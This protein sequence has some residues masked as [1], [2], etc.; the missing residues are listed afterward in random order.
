MF[1]CR[2]DG[3]QQQP[4]VAVPQAGKLKLRCAAGKCRLAANGF[5]RV[6]GY[7]RPPLPAV[8][9]KGAPVPPHVFFEACW[10][11]PHLRDVAGHAQRASQGDGAVPPSGLC[12]LAK[13]W[14]MS[15]TL[16]LALT[17]SI[18]EGEV[19]HG[20]EAEA[21]TAA[22]L[23]VRYRW[24]LRSQLLDMVRNLAAVQLIGA[25]AFDV[26]HFFTKS[27]EALERLVQDL[28][29]SDRGVRLDPDDAVVR[30]LKPYQRRG[31][32]FLLEH[33]GRGMIADEM[34]LG[35]TLQGLTA[36]HMYRDEWPLLIVCPV[37]LM[38]N[39]ARE[40]TTWL[41]IPRS[42]ISVLQGTSASAL[43]PTLQRIYSGV[44]SVV[45]VAYSSLH[46]LEGGGI[47]DASIDLRTAKRRSASGTRHD[48]DDGDEGDDAEH[49]IVADGNAELNAAHPPHSSHSD[50]IES[51]QRS[52]TFRV[53]IMD[54]SHYIKNAV[55]KRCKSAVRTAQHAH[56]LILLS[57]TPAMSRP[58]ELFSQL[59][60]L[61]P[62]RFPNQREFEARYCNAYFDDFGLQS[63]GHSHLAELHALLQHCM[64]RR[65]KR[66]VLEE[67]PAKTR[68][69]LYVSV[70]DKEK[71]A[72]ES[73]LQALRKSTSGAAGLGGIRPNTAFDLKRATAK[74]K[75]PA[76]RAFLKDLL[77]LTVIPS[78]EKVILFGHYSE[79]I[80]A[81]EDVVVSL[82]SHNTPVDYIKITGETPV[83]ERERLADHF[84][85]VATCQVAIL[86]MQS[87]GTGHNFTCASL[88]VFGE[89]D[90]NPS[91][92]LQCEDRVHRI[93]QQ[94]PCSI[95]YLLAEGTSDSVIWPL[96]QAKMTVTTTLL[97]DSTTPKV[98]SV[99]QQQ[100]GSSGGTSVGGSCET[101]ER[102]SVTEAI[103][104]RD[105]PP[106]DTKKQ[107]T[108]D[109]FMTRSAPPSKPSSQQPTP[110]TTIST[111]N[112]RSA[113]SGPTTKVQPATE[114]ARQALGIP[115][116]S[117]ISSSGTN[118]TKYKLTPP[119][120]PTTASVSPHASDAVPA[121]VTSIG[122]GGG[123]RTMFQLQSSSPPTPLPLPAQTAWI[124]SPAISSSS[125]TTTT[126]AA[127]A[128]CGVQATTSHLQPMQGGL[129]RGGGGGGGGRCAP[130][131][132]V[133][134]YHGNR[135]KFTFAAPS[136]AASSLVM[137]TSSSSTGG[138]IPAPSEQL[139]TIGGGV[140][141]SRKRLRDELDDNG[142]VVL[143]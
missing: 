64:I 67:L 107:G 95:K 31:V 97:E 143:L 24:G 21:M 27:F 3:Q 142:D 116:H 51:A 113:A 139:A 92:H 94:Q 22:C 5:L 56:R 25:Q 104:R 36:A 33:G 85:N 89:L 32:E 125:P 49:D 133:A 15:A 65:R 69:I 54:E 77:E 91:T 73:E 111:T 134:Q 122:S 117:A 43:R 17:D 37:S 82:K 114:G 57:G 103:R 59:H 46:V 98:C 123:G 71:K 16:R 79:V 108:L 40:V 19:L 88:V 135:T 128:T 41:G 129:S 14:S 84:R 78:G 45:I 2:C 136:N 74:A 60:L 81:M 70:T 87:S 48:V 28:S 12:F 55:S 137:V 140:G 131:S 99:G 76:I 30:V 130:N 66:Q 53:V 63:N 1:L 72:M 109:A 105:A 86:S 102:G 20:S 42:R 100:G 96:L 118:R 29:D 61:H 8:M 35:K 7:P 83:T 34:G 112:D 126:T 110:P 124:G 90:W 141:D 13:T 132:A 121:A 18:W 80:A 93:G 4:P 120:T 119:V 6:D 127:A 106:Q 58:S 52:G 9:A 50:Q 38:E 11:A 62:T 47:A 75:V 23:T 44:Y 68:E 101:L 10:V 26:P 39:W 138:T 115:D